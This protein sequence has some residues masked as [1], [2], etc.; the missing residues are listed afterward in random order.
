MKQEIQNFK[1]QYGVFLHLIVAHYLTIGE[2]AAKAITDEDLNKL[3]ER[4]KAE[5]EAAEAKGKIL[6]M[7]AEFQCSL[8]E[9]CRKL[10]QL[11]S[12]PELTHDVNILIAQALIP[13]EDYLK[14]TEF[15]EIQTAY[16]SNVITQYAESLA[17]KTERQEAEKLLLEDE[18]MEEVVDRVLND[19][20]V[21]REIDASIDYAIRLLY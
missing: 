8:L 19:D 20:E 2:R 1:Q 11:A 18:A 15:K 10:A 7:T 16:W 3:Q 21:W 9:G 14:E 4:L 12:N 13:A 5:E 17:D 6:I